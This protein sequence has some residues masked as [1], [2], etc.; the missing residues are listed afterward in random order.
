MEQQRKYHNRVKSKCLE[1]AVE[2]ITMG[3]KSPHELSLLDLAC[4][5][6]SDQLK[7]KRVGIK[8]V[9]AL[10]KS[11]GA[12]AEARKRYASLNGVFYRFVIADCLNRLHRYAGSNRWSIISCNFALHYMMREKGAFVSFM[13]DVTG[14]LRPGGMFIG[15]ILNGDRLEKLM[16]DSTE[17]RSPLFSARKR[18]ASMVEIDMADTYYFEQG[19]SEEIMVRPEAVICAALDEGLRLI[20]WKRFTDYLA[21]RADYDRTAIIISGLY[22]V[23]AFQK[24]HQ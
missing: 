24:L 6:G 20:Y 5:P 9:L 18:G 21:V 17:Y 16:G 2:R 19:S 4:G 13:K 11:E 10:D 14:A 15:T 22:D 3:S 7:W 8:D 1:E 23:F 12:I